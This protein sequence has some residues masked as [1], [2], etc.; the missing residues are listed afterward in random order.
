MLIN[1]IAGQLDAMF[2]SDSLDEVVALGCYRYLGTS[3]VIISRLSSNCTVM[4]DFQYWLGTL[5]S[6]NLS[7][8]YSG[9]GS[10]Y[11]VFRKVQTVNALLVFAIGQKYRV[12]R[13]SKVTW[14]KITM[15]ISSHDTI[16]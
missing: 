10:F 12:P 6:P 15:K 14:L 7:T 3:S 1:S 11:I 9:G 4:T 5:Y 16:T 13:A 8:K 2:S